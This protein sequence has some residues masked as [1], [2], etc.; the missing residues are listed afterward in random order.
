MYF[1]GEAKKSNTN[2]NKF[3]GNT[4]FSSSTSCKLPI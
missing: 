2:Q 1:K 4:Q 3:T